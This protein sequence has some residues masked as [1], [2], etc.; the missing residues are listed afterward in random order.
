MQQPVAPAPQPTFI[1]QPQQPAPIPPVAPQVLQQ[2]PPAPLT[3]I[4]V[5]QQQQPHPV[6]E[7]INM[8]TQFHQA[9]QPQLQGQRTGAH[10]KKVLQGKPSIQTE[11]EDLKDEVASY[12]EVCDTCLSDHNSPKD[13]VDVV[14]MLVRSLNL[15]VITIAL[16]DE[17]KEN[18]IDQ[19]ASR[20]YKTAP[21]K[22]VVSCW[23]KAIIRGEGLDWKRLMK[24]AGDIHTDLAYWII[25]EGLDS[26]GY[27]PI[28]DSNK[29]YGFLFVAAKEHKQQSPLTSHLLDAC[30]S[31][32][33]LTTALKYNNGEWPQSVM[34][35]G[36]DIRNQFSLLM[37][38]MEMLKE[39]PAMPPENFNSLLY[40]CNQSIIESTQMLD[41]MTSEAAEK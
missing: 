13:I 39:G 30:G 3:G 33:G 41:S 14:H 21:T 24:V 29:I 32:I 18:L 28:R 6:P 17:K 34:N 20:G 40:S 37:G 1:Q 35:L 16:L 8:P 25:H 10:K 12:L 31:R 11:S 19:I 7:L 9:P 2:P 27:V 22:S 38:Y 4:I 26:I 5:P 36:K 15:D 23:E